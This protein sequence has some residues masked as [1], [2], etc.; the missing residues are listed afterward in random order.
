MQRCLA[1]HATSSQHKSLVSID[2]QL[3]RLQAKD[4][5]ASFLAYCKGWKQCRS[6]LPDQKLCSPRSSHHSM[7]GSEEF[8]HHDR[9][10]LLMLLP[11]AKT[12]PL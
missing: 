8:R 6:K 10:L 4:D 2:Q 7:P 3:D 11:Q 5:D 9:P 1:S 12:S